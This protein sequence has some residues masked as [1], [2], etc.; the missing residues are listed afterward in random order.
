MHKGTI[1][2]ALAGLLLGAGLAQ[3][4]T[5]KVAIT[6]IVD[7]PALEA[8]RDG[9]KEGLA[10][11]GYAEGKDVTF[12][13]ES[14]QGQAPTAVQ[15]ARQFVGDKAS[16]IVAIST[17]SAQAV[18]SA[19]K[20]IP[21]IFSAVTDPVGAQL[22]KSAEK[23]GGN[24]T[25]VSDMAP[26]ADQ[27]ALVKEITPNVKTIGVLFNPGEANSVTSLAMIKAAAE[28]LGL[29]V[30]EGPATKS[31]EV[32][33]AARGLIGKA[34]ALFVPTDNTIVSAFEA[35][36]GAA[37]QGKIPVYAADTDS[38]ARGAL[39]S[40]GFN[41]KQIGLETAELV[42][43]VLKGENPGDLPVVF[44]QGTDL[45]LNKGMAAKLGITLPEALV[46][47]ATKVVD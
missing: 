41:Y 10:K 5:P 35:A 16:V 26:F 24:V 12:V 21:V 34:D 9:V 31:A 30:V 40:V 13:Y 20:S 19:T 42:A 45:Y 27:L 6:A 44:A 36:V 17:P 2:G 11:A 43:K 18:A 22:V 28:K 7:H 46:A 8:V 3:A 38:V 4:Q 15:I 47:R 39:A 37:Q 14:A 23:P 25:G 1:V 29:A 33:A 32:Q